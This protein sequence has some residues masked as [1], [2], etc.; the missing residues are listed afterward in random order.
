MKNLKDQAIEKLEGHIWPE[1]SEQ[2]KQDW[3][4]VECSAL[5]K[6]PINEFTLENLRQMIEQNIGLQY[7]VPVAIE[8]DQ[9]GYFNPW[10]GLPG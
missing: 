1:L 3:L 10:R 4:M 9:K 5:R 6:K 7:L 8:R 2:D